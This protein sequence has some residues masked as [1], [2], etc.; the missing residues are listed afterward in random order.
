[1]IIIALFLCCI[2]LALVGLVVGIVRQE[3]GPIYAC[4]AFTAAALVILAIY[5]AQ[6]NI[7]ESL[8]G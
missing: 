7:I 2:G 5:Y 4:Y 6:L 1:M 8:A 3:G